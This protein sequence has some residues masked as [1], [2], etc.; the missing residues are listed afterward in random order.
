MEDILFK[1]GI[2]AVGLPSLYCLATAK[3]F[4]RRLALLGTIAGGVAVWLLQSGSES[5]EQW[6]FISVFGEWLAWV[7]IIGFMFL[8]L[9]II[10][11]WLF[12]GD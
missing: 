1:L 9:S 7:G 3:S 4:F 5:R 6:S 11:D 8:I 12:D 10:L 2:F